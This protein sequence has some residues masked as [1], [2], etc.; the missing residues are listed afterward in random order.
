MITPKMI[1]AV[2]VTFLDNFND[3]DSFI[4]RGMQAWLTKIT[5]E[6]DPDIPYA[7]RLFFDLTDFEK[8]NDKYLTETFFENKHTRKIYGDEK[9][10]SGLY[11]AK[12]AGFYENKVWFIIVCDG[13]TQQEFWEELS[14]HIRVD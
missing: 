8:E 4:E 10:R 6:N 9:K 2:K 5:K 3:D 7:Y 1:D 13:D 14:K 12:E 11:T